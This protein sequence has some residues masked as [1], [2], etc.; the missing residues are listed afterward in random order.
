MNEEQ[1][2]DQL[3][4]SHS[5]GGSREVVVEDYKG[6]A[7]RK[8]RKG[9]LAFRIG[10]GRDLGSRSTVEEAIASID[11]YLE[12]ERHAEIVRTRQAEEHAEEQAKHAAE[13]AEQARQKLE[14][15][16]AC[17][18]PIR[19]FTDKHGLTMLRDCIERL[20][21][22]EAERN[23]PAN[24]EEL[25]EICQKIAE[26]RFRKAEDAEPWENQLNEEPD[27]TKYG[28]IE[29]TTYTR[30]DNPTYTKEYTLQGYIDGFKEDWLE[31]GGEEEE[32]ED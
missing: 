31:D 6:F 15:V 29:E 23:V 14:A 2:A 11:Q 12:Q 27:V 7:V 18:Q 24:W 17:I 21:H 4:Q 20:K 8:C 3:D 28:V 16:L 13:K 1:K 5:D 25:A 10:G 30:D 19:D 22:E 26:W 9:F 32:E